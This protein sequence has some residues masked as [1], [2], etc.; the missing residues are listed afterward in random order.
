ML[1]VPYREL[2]VGFL[3]F[4]F[5]DQNLRIFLRRGLF[6]RFRFSNQV[7]VIQLSSLTLQ[8]EG[9]ARLD[10]LHILKSDDLKDSPRIQHISYF[11]AV[12]LFLGALQCYDIWA[13]DLDLVDVMAPAD[14]VEVLVIEAI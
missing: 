13:A 4:E 5:L 14:F 9:N 8:I 12:E 11:N 2:S 3:L 1:L 7:K 6:I 10:H